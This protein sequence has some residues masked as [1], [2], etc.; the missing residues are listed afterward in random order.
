MAPS[1]RVPHYIYYP[2][3]PLCPGV[4]AIPA[5]RG[6]LSAECCSCG[7]IAAAT[8]PA[9]CW[10]IHRLP[11]RHDLSLATPVSICLIIL[12]HVSRLAQAATPTKLPQ[13]L[14]VMSVPTSPD[15][16][17]TSSPRLAV[18]FHDVAALSASPLALPILR[19]HWDFGVVRCKSIFLLSTCFAESRIS[20]VIRCCGVSSLSARVVNNLHTHTC[21]KDKSNFGLQSLRLARY[22]R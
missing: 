7:G 12:S 15:P 9:G 2:S 17:R 5:L 1:V 22:L 4:V 13:T 21:D 18:H 11:L 8:C 14:P 6:G 16:C 19:E 3:H 20:S 10:G